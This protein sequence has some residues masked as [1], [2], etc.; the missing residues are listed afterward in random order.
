MFPIFRAWVL[1]VLALLPTNVFGQMRFG[2]LPKLVTV[3]DIIFDLPDVEGKNEAVVGRIYF[4]GEG[5][6]LQVDDCGVKLLSYKRPNSLW[7]DCCHADTGA[8]TS[9]FPVDHSVLVERIEHLR[10]LDTNRLN[11]TWTVVFGRVETPQ[12]PRGHE[13][14]G[15][16]GS[17]AQLVIRETNELNFTDD[18]EPTQAVEICGNCP[19]GAI[20]LLQRIIGEVV[21]DSGA[22]IANAKVTLYGDNDRRL[23]TLVTIDAKGEFNFFIDQDRVFRVVAEAACFSPTSVAGIAQKGSGTIVLPPITLQSKPGPDCAK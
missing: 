11:H 4:D 18:G 6:W 9:S 22:G 21:D 1:V 14:E 7:L 16:H 8:P 19:P 2:R 23:T 5:R 13:D 12:H 3:C 17:P 10:K 20:E 15:F